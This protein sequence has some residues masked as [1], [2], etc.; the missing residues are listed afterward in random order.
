MEIGL[1]LFGIAPRHYR[2]VARRAEQV[3][4]ESVW[5]GEHLALP[6]E[7]PNTYPYA[8]D[9]RAPVHPGTPL[10]DP[11][12]TLA[13][14]SAG[15]ERILLGTS[16]YIL[17]LR[18]PMLTARAV[19]TLDRL[20]GGRVILGAGV[21]WLEAEYLAVGENF[22]NRGRRS[23]EILRILRAL[24][25]DEVVEFSG[26]FYDIPPLRFE[27]KPRQEGGPP[28]IFGGESDIALRRAARIADGWIG[29]GAPQPEELPK[30]VARLRSLREEAGGAPFELT[31]FNRYRPV[32]LETAQWHRELGID[33]LNLMPTER[34]DGR[35]DV[36]ELVDFVERC[37]EEI[38]APLSEAG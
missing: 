34:P 10:Y 12:V 27:P 11:W 24:W 36:Q 25:C 9:G 33:R 30:L 35:W 16:V 4:F 1:S 2:D 19:T 23:E 3:G 20:S 18:H 8:K 17:P 31:T 13:D 37:G 15:T 5:V 38:I 6:V 28:V 29:S 22:R 21:G 32:N 7:I 14:I 26:E